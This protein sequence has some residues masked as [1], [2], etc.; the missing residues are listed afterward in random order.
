MYVLILLITVFSKWLPSIL[1]NTHWL[2]EYTR[3]CDHPSL[4]YYPSVGH[5]SFINTGL[6]EYSQDDS[7]S[8]QKLA[9]GQSFL[10]LADAQ[11]LKLWI[12]FEL[13]ATIMS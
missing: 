7:I 5:D 9:L 11:V 2:Q 3:L 4:H 1:N 10:Q 8:M 13:C 12:L 6:S